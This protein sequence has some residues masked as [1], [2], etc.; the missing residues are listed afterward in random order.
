V[1]RP[2]RPV[3]PPL[4]G[5]DRLIT[6]VITAGFLVALVVLLIVRDHLPA[7]DRWWIWVAASG[8]ALGLFGLAYVPHLKRS[9][10]RAAERRRAARE[11][12]GYHGAT[13]IT[14]TDMTAT[15]VSADDIT[16][17]PPA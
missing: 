6:A 12:N 4:E 3:P 17:A 13:D 8:T 7:A 15:D 5:D 11:A 16:Q 10:E 14:A 1:S 9:R 2:E